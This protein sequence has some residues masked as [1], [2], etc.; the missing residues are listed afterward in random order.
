MIPFR[1][2]FL[3]FLGVSVLHAEP[4]ASEAMLELRACFVRATGAQFAEAMKPESGASG[5]VI[6]KDQAAEALARLQAAKARVLADLRTV[7]L[8]GRETIAQSVRELRYPTEFERSE[9]GKAFPT[10][11]ETRNVGIQ[12]MANPEVDSDGKIK[13][14]VHPEVTEFLG[15]I[16][17]AGKDKP[18]ATGPSLDKRLNAP[19]GPGGIW[20]PIF[21][22]VRLRSVANLASGQ[23]LVLGGAPA[24]TMSPEETEASRERIYVFITATLLK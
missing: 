21:H 7:T 15:F 16:D 5:S 8:S 3:I 19:L 22:E 6:G 11:F 14:D 4:A 13:L 9:S 12:L 18:A 23:T 24:A 20:Q 10:A 17:Y 2:A 1:F